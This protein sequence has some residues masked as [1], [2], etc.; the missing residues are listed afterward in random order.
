MQA[1]KRGSKSGLVSYGRH[2]N[3]SHNLG[4]VGTTSVVKL[5]IKLTV[6]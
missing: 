2:N 4:Q 6:T 1:E 3:V 5:V